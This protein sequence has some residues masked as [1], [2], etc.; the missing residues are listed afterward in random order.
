MCENRFRWFGHVQRKTFDA[1]VR[2]IKSIIVKC[3]RSQERHRRMLEEQIKIKLHDFHLSEDLTR[4]WG[5]WRHLIHI[6]DY[7]YSCTYQLVF[8]FCLFLLPISFFNSFL[9]SYFYLFI[10]IFMILWVFICRSLSS[11]ETLWSYSPIWISIAVFRGS[12]IFNHN[13]L[14][15]GYIKYNDDDLIL[16]VSKIWKWGIIIRIWI[17]VSKK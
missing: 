14:W 17:F 15:T 16:N 2:R 4:D 12:P 13:L 10:C 9:Y 11:W 5:S 1:L 7:W 3:K 6:L 8:L